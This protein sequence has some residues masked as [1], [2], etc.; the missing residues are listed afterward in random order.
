MK[1]ELTL[2]GSR[3]HLRT[4]YA[5]AIVDRLR[6][7]PSRQFHSDDKSWSVPAAPDTLAMLCDI[8]GI[9]PMMLPAEIKKHI[10]D[11]QRQVERVALDMSVLDGHVFKTPPMAHQRVNLARLFQFKRWLLADEM[12]TGKS[13]AIANRIA[14]KLQDLADADQI[15]I[16]CPKSVISSWREQIRLHGMG[17]EALGFYPLIVNYERLLGGNF[18]LE[19]QWRLIVFDEIQRVK[20]F[21]AQTTRIARQL[22]RRAEFVYGLSGTPAPNGLEDWHGVLSVIDPDLVPDTKKAFEER[23]CIKT[24]LGGDGPWVITGYRNVHELHQKVASVTS[25]VTKAECLDLPE[26]VIAP[27]YVQLE[28]EQKRVYK[29]IKKDAVARLKSLKGEGQLT[30][31]NVL[32]ES[33]RLLQV[34]GGFVPDDAGRTHELPDKAKE[35][36]LF[37]IIDEIGDRQL[38]VWCQFREELAYLADL[39]T[40]NCDAE[41]SELTGQSSQ[42]EREEAISR[43]RDGHARFFVGTAAAGGLGI[44]GLQVADTEVYYS[45]DFNLSTWLQSQDR[46]HRIG[47]KNKVTVIPLIATGTIDEKIDQALRDKADLQEMLL[48]PPE[49]MFG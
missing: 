13:F 47:Q 26:K 11:V 6:L 40:R 30:V 7:V 34:V 48:V 35:Q 8:V 43:F 17:D 49:E 46:L 22:S 18:C 19:Q 23:Y 4:P 45:R 29:E 37:E 20:N 1:Y 39:L 21:T 5:P 33:L 38:V 42:K 3:V 31:K 41:V 2:R 10:P 27:R 36:A 44:N 15:L 12:G 28:G 24:R 16:V 9:L 32:S 14:T 25:R